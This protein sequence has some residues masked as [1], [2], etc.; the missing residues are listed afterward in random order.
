VSRRRIPTVDIVRGVLMALIMC[1]HGLS[2]VDPNL[3]S[4]RAVDAFRVLLSG[5]VGFATVSGMLMGYFVVTKADDIDRVIHRYAAR[6]ALLVFFAHPLIAVALYGPVG[7]GKSFLDFTA[8]AVFITDVLAFIFLTVVPVLPRVPA[9]ARLVLGITF[10]VVG[11]VLL[12]M[13]APNMAL[14]LVRDILAGV[15]PP[16]KSVLRST[17]PLL[18]VAGMF[19]VGSWLGHRFAV[20]ERAGRLAELA[21]RMLGACAWLIVASGAMMAVWVACKMHIAGLDLWPVRRVLYPDYSLTTYPA[22]LAGTLLLVALLMTRATVGR[23]ERFFLAFGKTSL[24]SYIV[25]YYL[26]QTIPWLLHW[27]HHLHPWQALVYLAI[28]MP[29]MNAAAALYDRYKSGTLSRPV[30]GATPRG[31][32]VP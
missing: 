17:Y 23:V 29:L 8:R 31:G 20:A 26:L 1:T 4:S 28:T 6:A 30:P 25:Q 16:A 12:L 22:Y 7:G 24:F 14:L 5:T 18:S 32:A 3:T 11:R 10:I 9:R 21:R 15:D 2:N 27:K 13:P 19:L